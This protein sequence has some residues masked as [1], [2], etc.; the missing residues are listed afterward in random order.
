[1]LPTHTWCTWWEQVLDVMSL[2][3][4]CYKMTTGSVAPIAGRYTHFLH[5]ERKRAQRHTAAT[6]LTTYFCQYHL[7]FRERVNCEQRKSCDEWMFAHT[8]ILHTA[9]VDRCLPAWDVCGRYGNVWIN[10]T[11][12]HLAVRITP[13]HLKD[14]IGTASYR[15]CNSLQILLSITFTICPSV[16]HLRVPHSRSFTALIGIIIR[17]WDTLIGKCK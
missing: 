3:T 4:S 13:S 15:G 1:M 11:R 8:S 12:P 6:S 9:R 2:S 5:T 17:L 7:S 10:V 16:I 14:T